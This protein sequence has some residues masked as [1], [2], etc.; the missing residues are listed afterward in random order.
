[1]LTLRKQMASLAWTLN[2]TLLV[3]YFGELHRLRQYSQDKDSHDMSRGNRRGSEE[4]RG[5]RKN[6]RPIQKGIPTLMSQE[7]SYSRIHVQIAGYPLKQNY[8]K[9]LQK[10]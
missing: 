4:H 3:S 10:H 6:A 2:H 5:A 8:L 9:V 7:Q 1:M